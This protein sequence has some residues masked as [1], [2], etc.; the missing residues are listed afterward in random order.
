M[1]SVSVSILKYTLSLLT[2]SFNIGCIA[3]LISFVY[4]FNIKSLLASSRSSS[5]LKTSLTEFF[6]SLILHTGS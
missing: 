3:L 4:L 6:I 2:K 1:L 5:S